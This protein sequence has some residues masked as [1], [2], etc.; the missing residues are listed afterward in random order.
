[1]NVYASTIEPLA[2]IRVIE[3][4]AKSEGAAPV[5]HNRLVASLGH[6]GCFAPE[7]VK[8]LKH[9]SELPNWIGAPDR[10]D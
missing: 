9:R 1:M 4:C 8:K 3:K 6:F 7:T 5:E 2:A 10:R